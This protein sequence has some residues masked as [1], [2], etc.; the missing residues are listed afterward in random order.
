MIDAG[1][2][3]GVIIADADLMQG[4]TEDIQAMAVVGRFLVEPFVHDLLR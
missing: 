2:D 4:A 3:G 1:A